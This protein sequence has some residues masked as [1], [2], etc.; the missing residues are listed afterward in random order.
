MNSI[1]PIPPTFQLW[2]CHG[3][4]LQRSGRVVLFEK[5]NDITPGRLYWEVMIVHV[6]PKEI[7]PSGALCPRREVLPSTEQW[8]VAGWSCRTLEEARRVFDAWV[9]DSQECG[10][11]GGTVAR[12]AILIEDPLFLWWS[13]N[14][15]PP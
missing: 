8:G 4:L 14:K 10:F 11:L 15:T 1:V 2:G 13:R 5:H 7:L 12:Q 9:A 3:R 6:R